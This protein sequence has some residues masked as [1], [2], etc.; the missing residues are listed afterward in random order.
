MHVKKKDNVILICGKDR[1]LRG[2]VLQVD[3]VKGRV[4]VAR[5]Q[6][7]KKH[8]KPNPLT[9]ESGSRVEVE[10]WIDASNVALYSEKRQGPVRTGK[11]FVGQGNNLFDTKAEAVESFGKEVPARI[12]KVRVA[13]QTGEVFDEIKDA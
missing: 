13:K 4:K 5:R 3:P 9:G 1:G 6:M 12:Q 7:M 2:E 10:G 8:R 11:K